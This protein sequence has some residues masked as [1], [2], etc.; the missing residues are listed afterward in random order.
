VLLEHADDR[1]EETLALADPGQELGSGGHGGEDSMGTSG[2][3]VSGPGS[4]GV[5]LG[6]VTGSC[7]ALRETEA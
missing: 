1:A 3:S 5:G 6:P 7:Y 2:A 4:R